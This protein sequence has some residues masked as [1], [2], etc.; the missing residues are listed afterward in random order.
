MGMVMPETHLIGFDKDARGC[1]LERTDL[2][3]LSL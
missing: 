1:L 2:Y 3:E